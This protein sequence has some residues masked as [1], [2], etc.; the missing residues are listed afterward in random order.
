[1]SQQFSEKGE[2]FIGK[3]NINILIKKCICKYIHDIL[4]KSL[5][6]QVPSYFDS[7]SNSPLPA[8]CEVTVFTMINNPLNY[9]S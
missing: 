1:M 6:D 8:T 4:Y 2:S 9:T 5:S 7:P 3:S